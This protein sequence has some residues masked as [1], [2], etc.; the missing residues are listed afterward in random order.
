MKPYLKI[1]FIVFFPV[2]VLYG[3]TLIINEVMA[4]NGI[5][6]ADEHNEYDDWIEIYNST[7]NTIDIAGYYF[8]DEFENLTKWKI[9]SGS[10]KTKISAH[11]F[12][13][14]WADEQTEQSVRHLNFKL[15]AKSDRVALTAPD[16]ITIVDTLSFGRQQ[17]NIS[18][19]LKVDGGSERVFF[20]NP[21]PGVSNNSQTSQKYAGDWTAYN[22][23]E[24]Y[25]KTHDLT[26]PDNY[27]HIKQLLDV[28]NF[29]EYYLFEI[30]MGNR[31]WL[32]NNIKFWRPR[33]ENGK[34]RWV[35][36]DTEYGLGRDINYSHSRPDWNCLVWA[37]SPGAGWKN[38]GD[39]TILI[40]VL[41]NKDFKTMFINRIADLMKSVFLPQHVAYVVDSLKNV[42]KDDV[43]RHIKRWG[44]M[45]TKKWMQ[46]IE[47]LK[48]YFAER[49]TFLRQHIINKF[50]LAENVTF[51]LILKSDLPQCRSYMINTTPI[52]KSNWE[53]IC[54]KGIP[55]YLK[56]KQSLIDRF[57]GWGKGGSI[58]SRSPVFVINGQNDLQLKT[59]FSTQTIPNIV[60]NEI[61]YNSFDDF[62]CKYWVELFNP[63]EEAVDLSG[64]QLRDDDDDQTFVFP[65]NTI[66]NPSEYLVI[67]H[68]QEKLNHLFPNI[69]NYIGEFDF[70]FGSDSDKVLLFNDNGI[71]VNI[72]SYKN[73][74]PWPQ[75]AD[76]TGYTLCLKAVDL[77]NELAENWGVFSGIGGTPGRGNE[78]Q[79]A[80]T[81]NADLPRTFS[82]EQNY[83]NPFNPSTTIRYS[84][85]GAANVT[86]IVYN[87]IGQKI[88]TLVSSYET[89]DVKNVV[90]NGKDDSAARF[91]AE[92]IFSGLLRRVK[93]KDLLS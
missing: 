39:N 50:N 63:E 75:Q 22:T 65:E 67:V 23:L 16:G 37:T 17:R 42:I 27:E 71:L 77:N 55:V 10:Q 66:L 56:I 57:I 13:I 8:S 19:G 31:D 11:G 40:R 4:K 30:Y 92:C 2:M 28:D 82:L 6:V 88:K 12:M 20:S 21:T 52:N 69:A 43:P 73:S 79:T 51:K 48:Q 41:Q 46:N 76:E 18:Y 74:N 87:M 84:L 32:S 14:F 45:N 25:I 34:W 85:S 7:N 64:W 44:G 86:L 58:I 3:K 5:A 70:G 36:W 81:V 47:S 91:P 1:I 38:T 60:I 68:N 15:S 24:D 35:L 26:V 33:R 9:P 78:I 59:R 62:K 61:N 93:R 89:P 54:F 80:V 90:W 49:P 83:P 29:A 72:V 53:G